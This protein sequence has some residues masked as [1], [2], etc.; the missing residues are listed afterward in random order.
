MFLQFFST[1]VFLLMF[2]LAIW[3]FRTARS[4]ASQ[5]LALTGDLGAYLGAESG[6]AST[7]ACADV[8]FWVWNWIP[9]PVR[10]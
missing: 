10:F 9:L 8:G 7:W 2:G 5:R 4:R 6:L 1:L 3:C